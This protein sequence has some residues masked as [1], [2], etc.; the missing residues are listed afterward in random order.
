[1]RKFKKLVAFAVTAAMTLSFVAGCGSTEETTEETT[2]A[3]TTEAV[4][5]E[6]DDDDTEVA[7]EETT[8]AAA[9]GVATGDVIIDINFDDGET[10][11]FVTYVNGGGEEISNVDG[12]LCVEIQTIGI[13]DYANQIYYDGFALY[14]G[15]VYEYSF[16]V[17]CDITRE[18]E[19]RLQI[20]GG[21]YHAYAI[22]VIEISDEVQHITCTFTMDE[23]SDPA[24][25]LCFNMGLASD[26]TGSEGV[27]HIYFDN[28]LLVAADA[29][30][31]QQIEPLPDSLNV[32]INQ[33]GYT[34]SESKVATITSDAATSYEII[35]VD[36]G[37]T[38]LSGSLGDQ[39]YDASSKLKYVTVDFSELTAAGT[40]KITTDAGDESYEFE[41]ADD[42]YDD[43]Y[44][45]IILM[46]YSQRCGCD[47]DFGDYSHE[48]CH[49][50]EAVIYG[51]TDH[52]DV[53]GGW[54]D[55]GDYGR[56]VVAAASTIED[57]LLAYQTAGETSDSIGIPESG[58]GVPDVLD[59]ARYE[60]EWMLKM[61]ASSGGV[62]HKVTCLVF[63]ETVM[64]T[65]ELDELVVAPISYAATGDFAAVMAK[66][67]TIYADFDA[68]F[69]AICLAAAKNAYAYLET[70][71]ATSYT[72]PDDIETGEYDD[73]FLGD[74]LLWAAV[75]LY[76]ATG[77]TSYKDVAD[78]L[79][80]NSTRV[81]Y[82]LGWADVGYYALYDYYL[83]DGGTTESNDKI[84]SGADKLVSIVDDNGFGVSI[85]TDFIWG[86]N[87]VVANNGSLFMMAMDI[88]GDSSYLAYAEAQKDYLL[89]RNCL[90]YCYVTG[91]GDLTPEN[92]HHRPSQVVGT[93]LKGMLVGGPDADLEDSYAKAVLSEMASE[94]CYAD[95]V[96]SYSCNEVT[97]Y[98]NSSLI[99][100][101]SQLRA[102]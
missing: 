66:A 101:M 49:T 98:W 63:P 41:I 56:Y 47:V 99:L 31:A 81:K 35:N 97:I 100:L 62:Y 84:V 25:R 40:Y 57:L 90:S 12:E 89:G 9:L 70:A 24:P 23:D 54:H 33:L 71:D 61:Q 94:A 7:E 78:D 58:N 2:E 8:E 10:G 22:D 3:E 93:A 74:E 43:L 75:E 46:L 13:L 30:N 14:E 18:I 83:Y 79:I 102:N 36:T 50:A 26:M 17:H 39:G 29:S 76:A 15:C 87:M 73:N 21:D 52:I 85:K 4:V 67:A 68:D 64:P 96:Q 51:T 55:A 65:E 92:P 11:D 20:N 5:E 32:N 44:T 86:S 77:D 45:D 72:N 34:S 28:I 16:D 53:S 80:S 42:V 1:M 38:V 82:G 59:E 88:T 6:A 27:H 91:Y 48:S 19:W 60:L 37:E 95:N 69:A